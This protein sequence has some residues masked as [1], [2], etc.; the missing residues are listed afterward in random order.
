MPENKQKQKI[1]V[2]SKEKI[3]KLSSALRKNLQRR[4]QTKNMDKEKD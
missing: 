4:K 1:P 2:K 3:I